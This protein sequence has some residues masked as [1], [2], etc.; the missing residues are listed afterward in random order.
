MQLPFQS[1]FALLPLLPLI[2]ALPAPANHDFDKRD[3]VVVTETLIVTQTSIVGTTT[4]PADP[5]VPAAT[6]PPP[7]VAAAEV[8]EPVV[9]ALAPAPSAS[10]VPSAAWPPPAVSSPPAPAAPAPSSSSTEASAA[11]PPASSASAPAAATNSDSSGGGGKTGLGLTTPGFSSLADSGLGW[12]WNWGLDAFAL[13]GIEF[14]PCVWGEKMV[15]EVAGKTFPEGTTHIMSFNEPDMTNAVGGSDIDAAKAASLHQQWTISL[16]GAN[17]NLKIGAPAVARGSTDWFNAWTTA[18]AG[19]C[20][21]DF[22]P[23]HFY[24][25]N[26]DELISYVKTFPSGGKPIWITE[27][28]CWDT[29]TNSIC[30]SADSYTFM[31]TTIAWFTSDEGSKLVER[32]SWFGAMPE[33]AGDGF[34]LEDAAGGLNDLGKKYLAL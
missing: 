32:W 16:T 12:Y 27:F 29:S 24:G 1:L 25:T 28:A 10:D 22:V 30:S 17:A 31:Q 20:K 14:V 5:D 18:C 19:N 11:A 26:A 34:G 9:P 8:T 15:E 23:I 6:A 3:V 33:R 2:A 21:Y 7:V 13:P 4:V